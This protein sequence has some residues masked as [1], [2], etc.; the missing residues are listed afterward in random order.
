M[1]MRALLLAAASEPSAKLN[2]AP[3]QSALAV[4]SDSKAQDAAVS[5]YLARANEFFAALSDL[6]IASTSI[7]NAQLTL[8]DVTNQSVG[9]T[10]T[11]SAFKIDSTRAAARFTAAL[12]DDNGEQSIAVLGSTQLNFA[13]GVLVSGILDVS[14]EASAPSQAPPRFS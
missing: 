14:L 1:Q 4:P 6:P 2:Q 8:V 9:A 12:A 13:D 10:A 11:A 3:N 5:F 7:D